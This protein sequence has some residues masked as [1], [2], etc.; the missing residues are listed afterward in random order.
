MESMNHLDY[1]SRV[2]TEDVS[3]LLRK[4]KTYQGSWRKNGGSHAWQ[5]IRRKIDRLVM[6][7]QGANK[8]EREFLLQC[9]RLKSTSGNSEYFQSALENL[10]NGDD[11][12]VALER[13]QSGADGTPLAEVRD[14]RRYLL[15]VEA[16]MM[17]EAEERRGPM[18]TRLVPR[19]IT[20]HSPED[21]H[22]FVDEGCK[23]PASPEFH[24]GPLSEDFSSD[25]FPAAVKPVPAEDSNRHG[26]RDSGKYEDRVK[27][28][29]H[30]G[31]VKWLIV[32]N[33]DWVRYLSPE[34]KAMYITIGGFAVLDR[35][36]FSMEEREARFAKKYDQTQTAYEN[37]ILASWEKELYEPRTGV[38][39][40]FQL[41]PPFRLLWG[42]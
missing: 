41:K 12:F 9:A 39:G 13:D 25:E 8:N 40:E 18:A 29:A 7:L 6:M 24:D 19:P 14:L 21:N 2:A 1:L 30:D 4:E 26:P 36:K 28:I 35:G 22:Q 5:M 42:K 10:L 32:I 27:T 38:E 11:I 16:R 37:R 17:A 33:A 34:L 31:H 20:K 23:L 3:E 15:L